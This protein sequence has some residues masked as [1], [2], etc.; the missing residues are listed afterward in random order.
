MSSAPKWTPGTKR[1]VL[2]ACTI[3]IG[4]AIWRFSMVLAPFVIAV[5]I[6]YLLNPI[7]NWLN[8]YTPLKRGWAAAIVY[9]VFL[10]ILALIPTLGTPFIVQQVRQL[11]FDVQ[12]LAEQLSSAMDHQFRVGDLNVNTSSLI[13]PVTVSLSQVFSPLASWTANLAVGIAG[14]FIWAVFILAVGFY[15]LLDANRIRA[16]VDSWIPP[17]Y[18]E[19]FH[20]LQHE[21]DGVWK[22]YF[23]GQVTLALLIATITGVVTALFGIRSAL[24]LALVAGLLE[25]VPNWGYFISGLIGMTFAYF[26]GSTYLTLPPWV[27][28]LL[29]GLF[30]L[31][32]AQFD[33][34][35]LAPRIIGYRLQ[36]P[37]VVIIIGIIAG[38]SV[39]GALGL[40]L[41]APTIATLRVLGSYIY[42]RLL[43]LEPY[44]ISNRPPPPAPTK[45]PVASMQV[46]VPNQSKVES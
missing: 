35:F 38:A 44:V 26:Q 10:F 25:W 24:I 17:P 5:I 14:G 32:L 22:A 31:V 21:I 30:Y 3:L 46:P 23:V 43:D 19:E 37:P 11:D 15:L 36:L 16:W 12:T 42:R 34:N 45:Q 40:L 18:L 9:L 27:F 6:A 7:V 8:R 13:E 29:I 4:W 33:M 1:A 20:Q 39:G 28:A 2:I 41:A